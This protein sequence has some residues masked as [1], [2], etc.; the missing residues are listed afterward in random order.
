ME[1]R[2]SEPVPPRLPPVFDGSGFERCI[3]D[4]DVRHSL[5]EGDFSGQ[6]GRW[7]TFE[8]VH[9]VRALFTGAQLPNLRLSDALVEGADFSGAVLDEIVLSRVEFRG[10]RMSGVLMPQAVLRDVVFTDCKL[11]G[12][13]FRMLNCERVRFQSTDLRTA[14]FSAGH[15]RSTSFFDCDLTGAEFSQVTSPGARFQGSSMIDIRGAEYLRG[16]VIDSNQVLPLAVRVF[17]GLDISVDD[18][19]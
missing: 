18:E 10:C 12:A 13:N 15:L 7:T 11:N 16:I 17:A 8:E 14:E 2:E 4:L 3:D 6:E 1:H 19:R 9:I 5:I